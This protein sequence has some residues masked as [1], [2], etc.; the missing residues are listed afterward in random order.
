MTAE[1]FR[2]LM[3]CVELRLVQYCKHLYFHDF[4]WLESVCLHSPL[5][6]VHVRNLESHA[7]T[8]GKS[9]C[10]YTPPEERVH[11]SLEA[12]VFVFVDAWTLERWGISVYTAQQLSLAYVSC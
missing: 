7:D 6:I 2:H 8:G 1:K 9:S 4:R 3:F 10:I 11:L 12:L 5:V